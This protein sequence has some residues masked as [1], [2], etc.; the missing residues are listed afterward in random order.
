MFE[1]FQT[2]LSL[3]GAILSSNFR[4]NLLK[5]FCKVDHLKVGGTLFHSYE[6]EYVCRKESKFTPKTLGLGPDLISMA[7]TYFQNLP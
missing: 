7:S 1:Q 3:A 2:Y 5:L 6:M 4:M